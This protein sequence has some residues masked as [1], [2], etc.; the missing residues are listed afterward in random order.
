MKENVI[1]VLIGS[2]VIL[3]II[4]SIFIVKD[5]KVTDDEKNFK[6]EYESFNGKKSLSTGKKY[7]EIE[8]SEK[9]G[10]EYINAKE[11]IEILNEGTGVIYFGF[12]ECPWCRNMIVPFLEVMMEEEEN[13]YYCNAYSIRDNK[14]LSEDGE[15]I[16]HEEGTDEYYKILELLGDKADVYEGLND[17]SIKRLYFP[18]VVF[19]KNGKVVDMHVS[20]VDSQENP[21][22]KLND[23]QKKEL[24]EIYKNGLKKMRASNT[25][26][27]CT[28]KESC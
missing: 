20:T 6:K 27:V 14:E 4:L 13:V 2:I 25:S 8:I 11:A 24:K 22:K 3:I 10:V 5:N 23:K 1:K 26:D 12:P 19:V 17:E 9:N 28:G 21:Y 16:T 15:I 7:L 18:T